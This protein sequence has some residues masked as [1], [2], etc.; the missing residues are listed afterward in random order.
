[1]TF[2]GVFFRAQEM[3]ICKQPYIDYLQPP[4]N[5]HQ[6]AYD[7]SKTRMEEYKKTCVLGNH[8]LNKSKDAK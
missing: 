1:M 3:G 7:Q 8:C 4:I 6:N 5:L 2:T